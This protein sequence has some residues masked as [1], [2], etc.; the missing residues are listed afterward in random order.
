M[1]IKPEI[2]EPHVQLPNDIYWRQELSA[3]AISVWG[4]YK[5]LPS[6]WEP[7]SEHIAQVLQM[8][9]KTLNKYLRELVDKGYLEKTIF[10]DEQGRFTAERCI[11]VKW[12]NREDTS[13]DELRLNS[14]DSNTNNFNKPSNAVVGV[15][16]NAKKIL[17]HHHKGKIVLWK[18]QGKNTQIGARKC[19]VYAGVAKEQDQKH[20]NTKIPS[21]KE[22]CTETKKHVFFNYANAFFDFDSKNYYNSITSYASS[23]NNNSVSH[24]AF[25]FFLVTHDRNTSGNVIFKR[26]AKV[27]EQLKG[28]D[29][30]IQSGITFLV[31]DH[32]SLSGAVKPLNDLKQTSNTL[33]VKRSTSRVNSSVAVKRPS[34]NQ[35]GASSI[36]SLNTTTPVQ[37]SM[38]PSVGLSSPV[39]EQRSLNTQLSEGVGSSPVASLISDHVRT[40]NFLQQTPSADIE[41]RKSGAVGLSSHVGRPTCAIAHTLKTAEFAGGRAKLTADRFLSPGAKLKLTLNTPNT[42][43][44]AKL[45]SFQSAKPSKTPKSRVSRTSYVVAS[46]AKVQALASS[47]FNLDTSALNEVELKAFERFINY[48]REHVKVG[49]STKKAILERLVELKALGADLNACVKQSIT[50]GWADIFLPKVRANTENTRKA[51]KSKD[52]GVSMVDMTHE[53]IAKSVIDNLIAMCPQLNYDNVGVALPRVL[54]MVAT[55]RA[56]PTQGHSNA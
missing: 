7:N 24:K 38:L 52:N 28:L 31:S 35:L 10:K 4:F 42:F 32:A 48:R 25:S 16:G 6:D 47:S 9:V 8:D 12:P 22:T 17:Q 26:K 37:G 21:Y 49:Y 34:S 23:I 33:I 29:R 3:T 53:S 20:H 43:Q 50:R 19:A 14:L 27:F 36:A 45:P 54:K 18:K 44:S 51:K 55:R 46:L 5:S 1:I 30:L 41:Q 15:K 40:V 11:K 39:W 56:N 13:D 2:N